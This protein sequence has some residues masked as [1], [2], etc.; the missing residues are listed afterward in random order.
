MPLIVRDPRMPQHFRGRL[1][2]SLTLNVDLAP[3]ILGAAGIEPPPRM[4]GRDFSEIYL[5][6][7]KE[8]NNNDSND[9][10]KVQEPAVAKDPWRTEFFYEFPSMNDKILPSNSAV[11]RH[12]LKYIYWP[13]YK[14]EQFFNETADPL[15]ENDVINMTEYADVIEGFRQRHAKYK[16]EVI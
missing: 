6:P 2:D 5:P 12:D 11:V 10:K 13:R 8:R 3:T 4:Q 9:S 1:D 16:K 7:L 14:F 15:E